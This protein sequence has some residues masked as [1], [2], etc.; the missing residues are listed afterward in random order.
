MFSPE[1]IKYLIN[2][3]KPEYTENNKQVI[4]FK[5][6][7]RGGRLAPVLLTVKK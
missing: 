3:Q 7:S 6:N 1:F 2:Y 4:N 5:F